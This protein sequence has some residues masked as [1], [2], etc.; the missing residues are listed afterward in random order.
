MERQT[1]W[2]FTTDEAEAEA[3]ELDDLE[4]Y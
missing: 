4:L 1:A 2:P 3:R